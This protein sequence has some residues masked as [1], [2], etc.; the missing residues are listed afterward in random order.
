MSTP[1]RLHLKARHPPSSK[2]RELIASLRAKTALKEQLSHAELPIQSQQSLP[3]N[4]NDILPV[5]QIA[6][7]DT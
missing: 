1:H 2:F 5:T 4:P 7:V 6:K 3:V